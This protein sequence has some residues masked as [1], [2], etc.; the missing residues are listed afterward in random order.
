MNREPGFEYPPGV[1]DR[2]TYDLQT[3]LEGGWEE[4]QAAA[5]RLDRR[6][7]LQ[8]QMSLQEYEAIWGLWPDDQQEERKRGNHDA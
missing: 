3:Y 5:E 7:V 1:T 4:S 8:G 2:D 6:S